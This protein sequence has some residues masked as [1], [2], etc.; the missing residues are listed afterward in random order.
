MRLKRVVKEIKKNVDIYTKSIL[1]N[2]TRRHI[3]IIKDDCY[4][5][6]NI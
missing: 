4:Q 5:K 3:I 2:K 6:K 1:K